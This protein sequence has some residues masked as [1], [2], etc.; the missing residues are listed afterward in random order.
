MDAAGYESDGG[1]DNV[2][3][4]PRDDS[5]AWF[6]RYSKSPMGS[7]EHLLVKGD[8]GEKI[9]LVVRTTN[10]RALTD[11][12]WKEFVVT[13]P[14][15][16]NIKSKASWYWSRTWGACKRLDTRWWVLT[17]WQKWIFGC[18]ND[19]MTHGWTSPIITYDSKAPTVLEALLYWVES[20]KGDKAGFK[21]NAKDVS[22]L[23][24]LFPSNPARRISVSGN[25]PHK[26]RDPSRPKAANES[27]VEEDDAEDGA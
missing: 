25:R 10:S 19:D 13:G 22:S 12:D 14:Y 7:G 8:K 27:D 20:A 17:D 9:Q 23:P 1:E 18:F 15:N 11:E 21:P 3:S 16:Y 5:N 26:P 2:P 4:V 24:A 6:W